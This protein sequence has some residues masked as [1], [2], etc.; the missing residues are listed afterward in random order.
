MSNTPPFTRRRFLGSMLGL[1]GSAAA[2]FALN[3]AAMRQAA[4][5]S[6]EV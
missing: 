4:A 2:P 6:A 3:L 5:Q 1:A